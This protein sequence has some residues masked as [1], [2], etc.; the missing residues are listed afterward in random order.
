MFQ[1]FNDDMRSTD[2]DTVYTRV[3]SHDRRRFIHVAVHHCFV[4]AS[5]LR[6]L[7]VFPLICRPRWHLI[8]VW[9][10]SL[11]SSHLIE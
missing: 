6:P 5:N 3:D 7:L 10:A 1:H 4:S 9:L 8:G 2:T 11:A